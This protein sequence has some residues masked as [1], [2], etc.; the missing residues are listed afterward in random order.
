MLAWTISALTGVF[1]LYLWVLLTRRDEAMVEG[2][3]G[4]LQAENRWAGKTLF[5]RK[6]GWAVEIL[7]EFIALLPLG[8]N[9]TKL[10][11]KLVLS[12][13]PGGL[14]ADEFHATRVLAILF[15]GAAGAFM[16]NELKMAPAFMVVFS[17]LGIFYPT[18]WLSGYIQKRRRRIFRDLPDLLDILRLSVDAGL[19][20]GSAM[21]VVVE[22]GRPGPLLA[23]LEKVERDMALGRG[24]Q[25]ALRDF[26]DRLAMSEINAFVL[27]LIQADQLGAS[28]GPVLKAQSE[29][30]RKRRWQLAEELVN[31]LP[32]KMLGPLVL[33]IFPASF[34]I[35]FTPLL[36]QYMQEG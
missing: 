15:L 24:R 20:F 1:I 10:E 21:G 3:A 11:R 9:R 25:D 17:L 35:L 32:M 18:L 13:H 23:E 28:I 7:G 22:K 27:A 19:D 26:A 30:A 5:L 14:S 34:I 36:I 4:G 2:L 33:F 6:F 29:M 16:D 8:S 12:G 31:K